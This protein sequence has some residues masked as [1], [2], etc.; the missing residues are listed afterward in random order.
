MVFVGC[1]CIND[2]CVIINVNFNRR[3]DCM[4]IVIEKVGSCD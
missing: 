4:F 3:G 2:C 1:L